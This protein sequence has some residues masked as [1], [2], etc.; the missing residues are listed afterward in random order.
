MLQPV[1]LVLLEPVAEYFEATR[2]VAIAVAE[3]VWE[4]VPVVRAVAVAVGEAELDE[5]P[6]GADE[7]VLADA[8]AVADVGDQRGHAAELRAGRVWGE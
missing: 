5:F 3:F 1:E 4:H 7:L 6:A 8:A 2:D